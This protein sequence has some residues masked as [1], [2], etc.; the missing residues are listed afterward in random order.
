M[1]RP[2]APA[3]A[4]SATKPSAG[5]VEV[6]SIDYV[7]LAER[8][9]KAWHLGPV[10]IMATATVASVAIGLIGVAAGA[11]LFWSLA[12]IVLGSLFGTFFSAFHSAQ[13]PQLGLPQM[14][15]SRPQFGYRGAVLVWVFVLISYIGYNVFAGALG[16]DTLQNVVGGSSKAWAPVVVGAALLLAVFGYDSIHR[17][18]RWLLALFLVAYAFFSV[19]AIT[20]FDLPDGALDPGRFSWLPFLLQFAVSAGYLISWA[21]YVSDYSRYLPPDVGVRSTFLWTYLGM[22]LSSIWLLSL[23]ALIAQ[24]FTDLGPIETIRTA[25]DAIFPGF[26]ATA[27]LVALPGL[28]I[29][30][31]LNLYGASLTLLAIVDSFKPVRPTARVRLT[32][33]LSVSVVGLALQYALPPDFLTAIGTFLVFLLYFFGP[34]TAINLVDFF[35]VRKG[36]YSIREIFNPH[37]MYGRWSRPGLAAY[38]IGFAA[39]VPFQ[40][41]AIY[42]GPIAKALDGID[43]AHFVGIAASGIAYWFLTRSLDLEAERDRIAEADLGLEDLAK[44]HANPND[45][46]Q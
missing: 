28:I 20:T 27:L 10:W 12:G 30:I 22:A 36:H 16:G 3:G 26:G 24:A 8:H 45:S 2:A 33:V 17:L 38:L 42:T 13:G 19:A 5:R 29:V 11:N 34:W 7:P 43:V 1:S 23:G 37:G 4:E 44:A 9:G 25:G 21:P 46:P 39:S 41:T 14:V 32:A 40:S 18:S 6:R 35:V 31:A 15:Q